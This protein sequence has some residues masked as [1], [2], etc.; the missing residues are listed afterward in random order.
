M[1]ERLQHSV[2]FEQN[3]RRTKDYVDHIEKEHEK[4]SHQLVV[5]KRK[6]HLHKKLK[7]QR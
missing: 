1:K 7:V 5:T 6:E 3:S 2:E 4:N